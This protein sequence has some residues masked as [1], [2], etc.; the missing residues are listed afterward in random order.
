MQYPN[1]ELKKKKPTEL[2]NNPVSVIRA[3]SFV[4]SFV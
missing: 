3:D 4:L 2:R 1:K